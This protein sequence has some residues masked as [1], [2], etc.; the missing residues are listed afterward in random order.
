LRREAPRTRRQ[1]P[2]KVGTVRLLLE[3]IAAGIRVLQTRDGIALSDEQILERARN[4]VAGLI[5]NYRI[6]SLE[7]HARASAHPRV[8]HQLDLLER[9]TDRL[10]RV[11][12][13]ARRGTGRPARA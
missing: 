10:D 2:T 13:L 8:V 3:D 7:A 6:R 12:H 9:S 1:Q 11:S 4:I 5:G